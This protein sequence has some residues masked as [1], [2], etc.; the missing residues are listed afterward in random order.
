MVDHNG[1]EGGSELDSQVDNLG[2]RELCLMWEYL[3]A[4]VTEEV[5]KGSSMAERE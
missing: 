2:G 1:P 5:T 4:L 3:I